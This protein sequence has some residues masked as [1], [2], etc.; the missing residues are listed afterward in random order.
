MYQNSLVEVKENVIAELRSLIDSVCQTGELTEE[1][2]KVD[3][4]LSA[5]AERLETLIR[6]N[7]RV[8]QDQ[9]MYL[10]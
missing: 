7:A 10:K 1:R 8:A 2:D 4:E 6:E 5:L 9:T 3:H